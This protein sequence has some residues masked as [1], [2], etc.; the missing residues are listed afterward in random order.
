MYDEISRI[1]K[2]KAIIYVLNDYFG[3]N[4]VKKLKILD[5]GA[6]SGIMDNEISKHV[7]NVIGI[8]IDSQAI[9]FA[10]KKFKRKNLKFKVD[11][12]M[13][14]KEKPNTYDVVICA[15]VYEHVPDSA[16]LFKEIYKVL[17]PNGVCYLAAINS[18]W[19]ME[20]HYNLLFLSWLP[21]N[22]ANIY[23]KLMGKANEYYEHPLSYWEIKKMT[24]YFAEIDYTSKI[25]IN[26]KKFGYGNFQ[27]ENPITNFIAKFAKYF[28]PTMFL[29]LKK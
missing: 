25:V 29:L 15:H 2:A 16:K 18:L 1:K 9:K 23:V 19:P 24:T 7:N 4:K 20:P 5:V 13:N 27:I 21:R 17:K 28:T 6:S 12:A 3:T 10:Q 8:D 26:P 14:L 22:L 11:D